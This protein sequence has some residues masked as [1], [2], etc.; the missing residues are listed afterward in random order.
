V[1]IQRKW[2][3]HPRAAADVKELSR[4]VK[5]E[6]GHMLGKIR[7]GKA[8]ADEER[9]RVQRYALR[10]ET[11]ANVYCAP[12]RTEDRR[13]VGLHVHVCSVCQSS[14]SLA[15]EEGFHLAQDRLTD[16]GQ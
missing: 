1:Q 2:R 5:G 13:L 9:G 11:A 16:S 6:L 7:A 4:A 15:V 14:W 10:L 8:V 3:W 12:T